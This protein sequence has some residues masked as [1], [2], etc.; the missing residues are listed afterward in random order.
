MRFDFDEMPHNFSQMMPMFGFGFGNGRLGVTFQ[1]IDA[2]VATDNNL[3][4]TDGALITEVTDGSP[5]ADAGLQV[6]DVVTAVNNEAV[7]QEHTLR[8]R[9]V[10][11]E[12][13]D[14]ITLTVLRSGESQDI[15]V[16][17]GE[18]QMPDLS[19]MFQNGFQFRGQNNGSPFRNMPD[20]MPTPEVAPNA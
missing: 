10:A 7:D 14:T 12:A 6:N 9:L 4:V 1:S 15:E 18:P 13:G 19:N 11:Y 17:L 8:D 20:Q 16:T 3:D 5:A 2:Q